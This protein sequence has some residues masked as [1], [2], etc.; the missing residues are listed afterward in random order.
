MLHAPASVRPVMVNRSST[1]PLGLLTSG[2][3]PALKKNGKRASRTGPPAVM[4]DGTVFLAP[5][6]VASDTC[7][8]KEGLVPPT[9]GCAW[10]KAQLLELK[11]GPRPEPA[12]MVPDTESTSSKVSRASLKKAKLPAGLLAA[13]DANGPPAAAAPGRTPGSVWANAIPAK[14]SVIKVRV[15][16]GNCRLV[17]AS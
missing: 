4:K 10:Q 16:N 7:G 5:S 8:F 15:V 6:A 11:R 2:F 12:S 9:A 1:P 13:T 14:K 17:I 3:P